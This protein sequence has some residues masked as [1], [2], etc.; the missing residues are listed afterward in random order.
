[1]PFAGS[2]EAGLSITASVAFRLGSLKIVGA[3]R[4]EGALGCVHRSIMACDRPTTKRT[5]ASQPGPQ[6]WA[7]NART[8]FTSKLSNSR[9]SAPAITSIINCSKTTSSSEHLA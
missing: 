8:A 5:Q 4:S 9:A 6:C 2:S 7:T 3:R 1:M